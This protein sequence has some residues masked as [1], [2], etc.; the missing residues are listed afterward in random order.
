M[1]PKLFTFLPLFLLFLFLPFFPVLSAENFNSLKI[2]NAETLEFKKEIPLSENLVGWNLSLV[3]LGSDGIDEIV[4][5]APMGEEPKVKILRPDGS[6][7]NEF[8]AY[9]KNFK[10]GVSVVGCDLDGDG[11]SEIVTG[12]MS[13]GGPHI[14][15]FDGFG[16]TKINAG[17]FAIDK[18][19]R[20]EMS[21]GCVDIN[22]DKKDEIIA[23]VGE[24][25]KNKI[26]KI[27]DNSGKTI[28]EAKTDFVGRGIKISKIDL[29]G[30]GIEEILVSGGYLDGPK[31]KIYRGD[32]SLV[33]EFYSFDKNFKDGVMVI[34][35]DVNGDSKGDLITFAGALMEN[36]IKIL[37]GFGNE[38]NS[39]LPFGENF[40][41][42][43]NG[44]VGDFDGDNK[45]EIAVMARRTTTGRTDFEKYIEINVATQRFRYFEKGIMLGDFITSTG[46]PSTPTRLGEFTAFSKYKIAY[47]GADGQKWGMPYF[48]GFYTSGNL[49]N[50]I[51][52]LPFLDG[53]REGI[54]DL[55]RAVSHGCVR[56]SMDGTAKEV[57][58][59]VEINKTKIWVHK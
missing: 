33:N 54:W 49:V 26:I 14:R 57:Y 37:D 11:K 15:I 6:K 44:L 19:L 46:K 42:G 18:N 25:Y 58:D 7:I 2:Y 23:V 29:G 10:G 30:D 47:G 4:A 9:D 28:V 52:E 1:K 53:V 20:T 13:N 56:L 51:H 59:W 55:G 17:F 22:G 38:K 45:K 16:K 41:G 43:L 5:G 50:G 39:F 35:S 27:F 32:L 48:I 3:D 34:G 36:K 12:A 40:I 21:V 31:I 24:P 8:L